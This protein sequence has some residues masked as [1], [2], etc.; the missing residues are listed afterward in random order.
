MLKVN[1]LCH[2]RDFT[3]FSTTRNHAYSEVL[4]S[5]PNACSILVMDTIKIAS[6]DMNFH[7]CVP[8]SL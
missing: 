7:S 6:L 2:S 3:F 4:F 8:K 1:R 5:P